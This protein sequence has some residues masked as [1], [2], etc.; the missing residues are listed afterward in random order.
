MA[1]AFEHFANAAGNGHVEP[2]TVPPLE[3]QPGNSNHVLD[4]RCEDPHELGCRPVWVAFP[5][6]QQ[7]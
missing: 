4:P 5:P 2:G 1:Y 3:Y 6:G 7:K